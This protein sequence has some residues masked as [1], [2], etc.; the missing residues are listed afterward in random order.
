MQQLISLTEKQ[1]VVFG[2]IKRLIDRACGCGFVVDAIFVNPEWIVQIFEFTDGAPLTR[3][4]GVPV[5]YS[6]DVMTF[7]IGVEERQ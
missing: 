1:L 2:K 4:A 3:I 5:V 7:N 6:E